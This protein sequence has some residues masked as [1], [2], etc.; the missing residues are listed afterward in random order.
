MILK[1]NIFQIRKF[2]I[3]LEKCNAEEIH[4]RNYAKQLEA[5]LRKDYSEQIFDDFEIEAEFFVMS[6]NEKYCLSKNIETGESLIDSRELGYHLWLGEDALFA[7]NWIEHAWRYHKD[8]QHLH[9]GYLMHCLV[10]HSFLNFED[11]LM[12]DDV[13][14]NVVVRYQFFTDKAWVEELKKINSKRWM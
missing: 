1:P 9:F 3:L 2:E 7:E 10:F 13:K 5:R 6:E 12:I 8:F 4:A 11:L 14:I